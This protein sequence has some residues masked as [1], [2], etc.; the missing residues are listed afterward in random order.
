MNKPNR[1]DKPFKTYDEMIDILISRNLIINDKDYAK[2]LLSDYSYYSLI[3]GFKGTLLQKNNSDDFIPGLELQD[4][5]FLNKLDI[6][7]NNLLFKYIL[8]IERSLKSKLSYLIASNWGVF[9]NLDDKGNR[10]S[11]DYLCRSHYSTSRPSKRNDILYKIKCS[12]DEYKDNPIIHHY[13]NTKNHM[14]PWILIT[15]LSFGLVKEWYN[16]L[17]SDDKDIICNQFISL[18]LPMEDKKEFFIKSLNYLKEYC[19]KIAH[20]NRTFSITGLPELPKN[21]ALKLSYGA[22]TEDEYNRGIGRVDFFSIFLIIF[23]LMNDKLLIDDFY[24]DLDWCLG[25]FRENI[26]AGK[27]L[28]DTIGLPSDFDKKI[29]IL[30]NN[31][32]VSLTANMSFLQAAATCE[33]DNSELLPSQNAI[34]ESTETAWVTITGSK[35]HKVGHCRFLHSHN[36]VQISLDS[37]IALG[38]QRCPKCFNSAF[39][40]FD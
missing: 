11:N 1:F 15:V 20:G 19:N 38:Y 37:A 24:K 7:L 31:K 17:K 28:Y 5:Y 30:Y 27:G 32:M 10:D 23:S 4:I 21:A 26:F 22:I 35:Y 40:D 13:L 33:F 14:P 36:P 29:R 8:L 16:I 25:P 9:T 3:N 6:N 2:K 39:Y 18:A 12:A 34:P